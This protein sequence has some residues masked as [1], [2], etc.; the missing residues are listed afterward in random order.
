MNLSS[1]NCNIS[2]VDLDLFTVEEVYVTVDLHLWTYAVDLT[3]VRECLARENVDLMARKL[4][5]ACQASE[6][7]E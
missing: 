7:H 4:L 3:T 1:V 2:S 6:R 5:A